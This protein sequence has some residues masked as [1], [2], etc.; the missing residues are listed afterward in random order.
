MT[1]NT[2]KQQLIL[3]YHPA[4]VA[5]KVI[6]FSMRRRIHRSLNVLTAVSGAAAIILAP[7]LAVVPAAIVGVWDIR[8]IGIFFLC[9]ALWIVS[10]CFR[11]LHYY[12]ADDSHKYFRKCIDD[13]SISILWNHR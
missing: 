3:A 9:L 8:L 5:E 4:L 11:A 6:S 2:L 10:A 1:W 7:G 12:Y 13:T